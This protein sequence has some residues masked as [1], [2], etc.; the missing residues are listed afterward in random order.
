MRFLQATEV[1][2]HGPP[3]PPGVRLGTTGN[4]IS[5]SSRPKGFEPEPQ[6]SVLVRPEA[7]KLLPS[8]PQ[9]PLLLLQ[10]QA[11][12]GEL[13]SAAS[14]A[15]A[16]FAEAYP[17]A[18][19][20]WPPGQRRRSVPVVLL[21]PLAGASPAPPRPAAAAALAARASVV[22]CQPAPARER[23]APLP[24]RCLRCPGGFAE[25]P[26]AA[27]RSAA[28]PSSGRLSAEPGPRPPRPRALRARC[29]RG[30]QLGGGPPACLVAPRARLVLGL[31]RSGAGAG[32]AAW[33]QGPPGRP[34]F[35]RLRA[36]WALLCSCKRAAACSKLPP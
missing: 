13:G 24:A 11:L 10:G 20:C 15:R 26:V 30:Q 21:A 4:G 8:R 14:R 31:S 35:R 22:G 5:G 7:S 6:A 2:L 1:L 3:G 17:A 19:A 33:G 34:Q 12:G 25:Q 28:V 29:S 32:A 16:R 27:S 36:A 18:P 23:L 9:I